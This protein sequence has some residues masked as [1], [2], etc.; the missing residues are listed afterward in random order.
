MIRF[1]AN[2]GHPETTEYAPFYAS[3]IKNVTEDDVVAALEA[4]SRETAALLARIDDDKAAHRY[5][6]EKWSVKEVVGHFTDAERIFLYRAL[7]IARGDKG[8]LPGF[9]ENDYM[10]NANFDERPM[11]SIAEEYAAARASTLATF[12]GFSDEAWQRRGTANNVAVSVRALAHICLGHERHHLRVL[13][14]KYGVS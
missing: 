13:R 4:Q 1:M 3:Y 9:D 2:V 11:R 14:E 7:A 5:A 8:S 10:R 6:P 12:R